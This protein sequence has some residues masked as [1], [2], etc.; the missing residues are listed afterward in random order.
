MRFKLISVVCREY[1]K[2]Y[3]YIFPMYT[4]ITFSYNSH[5]NSI[6]YGIIRTIIINIHCKDDI[7]MQ[8]HETHVIILMITMMVHKRWRMSRRK[9]RLYFVN[10]LGATARELTMY[11][12]YYMVVDHIY[13]MSFLIKFISCF[14]PITFCLH[15]VFL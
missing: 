10:G 12:Y 13:L 3:I 14:K 1:N 4:H 11:M 6:W 8:E 15:G 7:I 2:I 5:S 9:F